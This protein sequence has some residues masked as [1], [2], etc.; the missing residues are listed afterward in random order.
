M[1]PV[2]LKQQILSHGRLPLEE[3][4]V[5]ERTPNISSLIQKVID[6][7][8]WLPNNALVLLIN[9][10]VPTKRVAHSYDFANT[11]TGAAVLNITYT[12]TAVMALE[13]LSINAAWTKDK[14]VLVEWTTQNEEPSTQYDIQRSLD[15]QNFTTVHTVIGKFL[16]D[17]TYLDTDASTT[18]PVLYYRIKNEENGAKTHFSSIV[19]VKNPNKNARLDITAFPNPFSTS[20]NFVL[21]IPQT[22]PIQL[23]LFNAIGQQ[24][25]TIVDETLSAGQHPIN[26]TTHVP[27]G[28]YYL[29]MSDGKQQIVR[30]LVKAF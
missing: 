4:G 8:D 13:W 25:I 5:I 21:D 16:N 29:K 11:S 22:A 3:S 6:R 15:G 18:I 23:T 1:S 20:V 24:L 12:T 9:G 26:W 27:S 19:S 7:A 14:A 17:Y 30:K 28:V 2:E 10:A